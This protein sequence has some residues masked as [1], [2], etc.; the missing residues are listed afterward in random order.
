MAE[1]NKC[2]RGYDPA[3]VEAVIA[4]LSEVVSQKEASAARLADELKE[5]EEENMVLRNKIREY[6]ET[7][8]AM[9][10]ALISARKVA[11]QM[12]EKAEQQRQEKLQTTQ[13]QCNQKLKDTERTVQQIVHKQDERLRDIRKEYGSWVSRYN[14]SVSKY[15]S[16]LEA[17]LNLLADDKYRV[18]GFGMPDVEELSDGQSEILHEIPAPQ[19]K[20]QVM[21]EQEKPKQEHVADTLLSQLGIGNRDE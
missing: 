7:E 6:K 15:R 18:E 9:Q 16:L 1:F 12:L 3:Q 13:A 2:F 20:E 10:D 11:A 14:H 8:R 19:V 21:E 17:Q 4:H 5:K